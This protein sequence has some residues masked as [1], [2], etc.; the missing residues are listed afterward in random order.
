MLK[1]KTILITGGTGSFGQKFVETV[2]R[3]YPGVQKII[4]YSRGEAAQYEMQQQYPPKQFPQ[5]RFFIGDVRDKERL[6]RA[7]EGVDVLIHVAG[8]SMIPTAEYNPDECVKTSINGAQNVI[9]AALKCEIKNVIA[10][11]SD[12]ACAPLN[13]FGASQLLSDKLFVA[14]NNIRGTKDV[15]FSI[16]RYGSVM[17]SY[18][19]VI[20]SFIDRRDKGASELP[21]TDPRMTRFNVSTNDAVDMVMLA[22]ERHLGG[23]IFIPKCPSY[24]IT[25]VAKAIA[26]NLKQTV[27]GIRPGEKLHEQMFSKDDAINAIELD[28]A[29]IVIP[30]ITFTG[31]RK[32]EDYLAYY[33]A[34][35]VAD[36]FRY[37]SDSNS[38]WETVLTIREKIKK[39]VNPSFLVK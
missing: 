3:D 32:K 12:K 25:D 20:P 24:H 16:V 11:S 17:G 34:K 27:V 15:K 2:L 33:N 10:L 29:Y 8:F 28:N 35:P 7:C 37:S 23:E 4:I 13:I 36:G 5:L 21:I 38:E 31:N 26:P 19:S 1:G 39:Y 30:S 6:L 14:A 22:I 18:G 9:D